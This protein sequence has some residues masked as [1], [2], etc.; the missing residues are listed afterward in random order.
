MKK[1]ICVLMTFLLLFMSMSTTAFAKSNPDNTEI[2]A[3]LEQRAQLIC[4]EEYDKLPN[5]DQQL[6]RLGVEKLTAEE[7]QERFIGD[8]V[9]PYVSAPISNN[10][11]WFSSRQDYRYNGVTYEIQTLIAQPNEQNSSLKQSGSRAISSTYKWKAGGMN[12]LSAVSLAA[13]GAIEHAN[14]VVTV[15]NAVKDLISGISPTTEISSTEIIYT[16][17]HTT[18]AN[19]KYVKIKG[20]SDDSQK[21]TFISTKG[22]TAI[23]YQF[24]KFDYVGSSVSP[25]VIQGNRILTSIPY[26]Y[27]SDYSAIQAYNDVYAA[28]RSY[29]NRV[30]IT[31][32]ESKRVSDI[33]PICPQFPLQIS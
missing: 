15:Y 6:A 18:T 28:T 29:V 16:Y 2:D 17:A 24:P 7:V 31:G 3:L 14:L 19:F 11:T 8:E 4:Y 33:A 12:L 26:A 20:Q 22:T 27:G 21:L 30:E 32:I 13:I 10:V 1:K 25:N 23:G 5:I 9:T